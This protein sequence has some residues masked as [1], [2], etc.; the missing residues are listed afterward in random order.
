[1]SEQMAPVCS[2][3]VAQGLTTLDDLAKH[4]ILLDTID[5]P[6][7]RS[8][9]TF[10]ANEV[11]VTL[12]FF[13]RARKFGQANMVIQAAQS[14]SGVA[15]G[16]GPLVADAIKEGSLVYPFPQFAQSQ[17]SYWFVCTHDA[18][19]SAEVEAFRLWLHEEAAKA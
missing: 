14:G 17:F 2:P 16:R 13:P 19:K 6:E 7:H 5:T 12:P 8:S 15:M 9:W 11:G 1:M 3:E 10:W 4:V 18:M